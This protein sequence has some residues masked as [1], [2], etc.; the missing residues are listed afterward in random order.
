MGNRALHSNLGVHL[1]VTTIRF[2]PTCVITVLVRQSD[3][4]SLRMCGSGTETGLRYARFSGP[5]HVR[6]YTDYHIIQLY[7]NLYAPTYTAGDIHVHGSQVHHVR[8]EKHMMNTCKHK[9][10]LRFYDTNPHAHQHISHATQNTDC[11]CGIG[12]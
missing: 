9:Q 10:S 7:T 3:H 11:G 2:K 12:S 1:T 5:L 8:T 6:L 4:V